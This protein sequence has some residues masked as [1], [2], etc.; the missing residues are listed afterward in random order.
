[1][2][3]SPSR[4]GGLSEQI[5]CL[6][7]VEIGWR[8]PGVGPPGGTP[9]GA[10]QGWAHVDGHPVNQFCSDFIPLLDARGGLRNVGVISNP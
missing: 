8:F 7:T 6:A 4:L 1:M 9:D 3:G 10:R 5:W 2:W